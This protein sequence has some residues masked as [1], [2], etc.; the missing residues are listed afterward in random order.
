MIV[1]YKDFK[2]LGYDKIINLNLLLHYFNG[3]DCNMWLKLYIAIFYLY[4]NI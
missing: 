3:M 2:F 1:L 4:R